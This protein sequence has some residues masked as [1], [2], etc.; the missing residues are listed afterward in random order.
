[1][2]HGISISEFGFKRFSMMDSFPRLLVATEFSPNASG[3]GPA[4]LRQMLRDWPADRL[5]W[6][7]CLPETDR[8]FG[9][10]VA[11]QAVA[12]IPAKLYPQR[13]WIGPKSWV[14][15][16]VWTGWAARHFERTL[17]TFKP[18]AIWVIPHGWSIPPLARVLGRGG[19]KFHVSL[20]DFADC[21][22]SVRSYGAGPCRRQLAMADQLY[23]QAAMRDAICQPMVDDLRQRTG[24]PGA[25]VRAGL[26]REDF[27]FL[28][29]PPRRTTGPLRIG[30][31]G[32]IL[33]EATFAHFVAALGK[34][35]GQLPRPATLEFFGNHSYRTRPWFDPAWM[36][37]HGNQPAATLAASL[38]ACDWGF[39]PMSLT[40]DDPRYNRFSLPTKFVSYLGAGLPIITLGH[41]ESS[42]VKM[43]TAHEVGLCSH[44]ADPA[45]LSDQ[46]L[47]ALSQPDAATKYRE[48]IRRCAETEFDASR[49]R[50]GLYDCFRH[51]TG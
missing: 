34:I 45:V 28:Q 37:E 49:M 40:D 27:D 46:L 1:L 3:G 26:E 19:R 48:G 23:A 8:T 50:A 29:T 20:H 41:P 42:V 4:V 10:Q 14:L 2:A 17:D 25:I 30:Y 24:K 44:A 35:R 16:Q 36:N 13:R 51:C 18:E 43:A 12:A 39:S 31:A 47:T 33:V 15:E 6:W 7:S 22:S 11:G 38:R 21:G 32:T 9:R 5:F